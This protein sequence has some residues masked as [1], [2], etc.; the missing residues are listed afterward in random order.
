VRRRF[1]SIAL[2]GLLVALS[3]CSIFGGTM[4]QTDALAEMFDEVDPLLEFV[5]NAAPERIRGRA[6][7]ITHEE[8]DPIRISVRW[9]APLDGRTP[10]EVIDP[11]EDTWE[12]R[13]LELTRTMGGEPSDRFTTRPSG[14]ALEAGVALGVDLRNDHI[15]VTGATRCFD[16]DEPDDAL[17]ERLFGSDLD[18]TTEVEAFREQADRR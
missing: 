14:S 15:E 9:F 5:G 6:C 11:I 13:G 17:L 10:Q 3:G 12:Q 8:G 16:P 2:V 1:S 7:R 18:V 4:N